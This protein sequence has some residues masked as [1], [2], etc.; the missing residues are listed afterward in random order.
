MTTGSPGAISS[1]AASTSL[2]AATDDLVSKRDTRVVPLSI[3]L[4]QLS[5]VR[6]FIQ[7]ARTAFRLEI[8]SLDGKGHV[9]ATPQTADVNNLIRLG[10][11]KAFGDSALDLASQGQTRLQDFGR[12]LDAAV[13]QLPGERSQPIEV[14]AQARHGADDK[15]APALLFAQHPAAHQLL[16]GIAHRPS[17][18]AISI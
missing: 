8:D 6:A 10:Q 18:D 11:A 13:P 7:N 16:N 4:E 14:L 9:V 17:A 12:G 5:Q 1:K 15:G 3:Q 2:A